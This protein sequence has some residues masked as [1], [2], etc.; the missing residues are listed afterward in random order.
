MKS[1]KPLVYENPKAI[2]NDKPRVTLEPINVTSY[3]EKRDFN[4]FIRLMNLFWKMSK[5]GYLWPICTFDVI[6][7]D[8]SCI[9]LI[10]CLC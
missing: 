5:E 6:C 3:E 10:G 8:Y 1:Q 9:S 4:L 2:V 7:I